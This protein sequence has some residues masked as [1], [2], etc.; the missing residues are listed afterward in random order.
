MNKLEY[1]NQ[2]YIDYIVFIFPL[3]LLTGPFFTD[4]VVVISGMLVLTHI[5]SKKIWIKNINLKIFF[6]F[7]LSIIISSLINFFLNN[8]IEYNEKIISLLKSFAYLRF[9]LFFIILYLFINT[10]N[11]FLKI[12]IISSIIICFLCLDTCYQYFFGENL[13]G[14]HSKANGRLTG[15]FNDEAIIG[16]VIL[17][18]FLIQSISFFVLKKLFLNKFFYI[19][20]LLSIIIILPTIIFTLE[21]T[22]L[23]LFIFSLILI[24]FFLKGKKI[25]FYIFS[26][27]SI[28][29]VILYSIFPNSLDRWKETKRDL[30]KGVFA[31]GYI[32]HFYSAGSIFLDNPVF[33]VG[34][35]NF[36]NNCEYYRSGNFNIDD[37]KFYKRLNNQQ[38]KNFSDNL[39]ST[40]PH[41]TYFELISEIG[42]Y[43]LITFFILI[44]NFYLKIY[45]SSVKPLIIPIVILL[46]PFLP[47]GSFFNNYNS[48]FFW[49][50]VGLTFAAKKNLQKN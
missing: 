17:K 31:F 2:K 9:F 34:I 16:G 45:K 24:I 10:K 1:I 14:F 40:H 12:Y 41:N 8:Q 23:L 21:R 20:Y 22:S 43:G 37:K 18:F 30:N 4:L 47:S 46:F 25:K 50:I 42:L 7:F 13:F 5:I 3:S 44:F 6:Y 49:L 33:G 35:K 36:R 48:A 39:C 15:I 29:I 11:H 32:S 28:I 38:K 19:S 26:F 27:L